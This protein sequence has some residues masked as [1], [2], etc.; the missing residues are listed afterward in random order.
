MI[1]KFKNFDASEF[2]NRK[3]ALKEALDTEDTS[4]E[5]LEVD[6]DVNED[7][8]ITGKA[9]YDDPF[10]VKIAS[11]IGK[12]LNSLNLGTFSI[13]HDIVYMNGMPGVWF[14]G[15]EGEKDIICFRDTN[16]KVIS[17]F[18]DFKLG[19]TNKAVV[20]YSTEKFGFKDMIDQLV[21]DLQQPAPSVNEGLIVEAGG[22]GDGYSDKNIANFKRMNW[23]DKKYMYD[24]LSSTKKG[25]AVLKMV[26]GMN[27]GDRD[28]NRI[29][30]SF[31]SVTKGSCKYIVGLTNDIISSRY[32]GV[33]K[34]MDDLI[35]E[36]KS[37]YTGS[38]PA[39][40]TSYGDE[41]ITSEYE[42]EE[43][44][45]RRKAIEAEEEARREKEAIEYEETINEL[46]EVTTAMCHYVK[47]NGNL[48]RDDESVMSRR[49]VLLTGKGGI[50]KTHEVKKVLKQENMVENKD[51]IWISLDQTTSDAIYTYMYDYNGKM[52]IFDDA[53]KLFDGEYR[54]AL[55]KN[56]LQTEIED[57]KIGYPKGESKLNVYNV[58]NLH[59]DRQRRYYYEIGRKSDDDKM[60]F[61]KKE[62]RKRGLKVTSGRGADV[63]KVSG[64]PAGFGRVSSDG[65]LDDAEIQSIMNKISDIWKEESDSTKPSMPNTFIFK[66]VVIIITNESRDKFIAEVGQGNWSAIKSR[67]DNFDMS[68]SAESIWSVIK[69][70]I[71]AE[72]GET[73]IP[74]D[75]CAIPRDIT[76]D[77]VT[78]VDALIADYPMAPLTWRTIK[79]FGKILRGE[80]GRSRWKRTLRKE[81][82]ITD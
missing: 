68:P 17:V 31:G 40:A 81:L 82:E 71:M 28:V 33:N 49:G 4:V 59:G 12:K 32:A 60:D 61:F 15:Q 69:K 11:I 39:I 55:W 19:G 26:A 79:A 5:N 24:L 80:P 45:A 1:K 72:Y 64:I 78:E 53:P 8:V 3:R 51:Y 62:M 14:Q 75:L 34:D 57:C 20:T 18:K 9:V 43:E 30:S 66:G 37:K 52:I 41:F 65:E 23:Y 54:I 44:E 27:S 76:E 70:K 42:D 46:S 16:R 10:L 25:D 67:F 77:F 58:R 29:L 48:S 36:Y 47:Q 38:G 73:S 22:Y 6:P 21:D 50:G 7:D 2:L 74:D 13:Y 56:A 63:S 35:S